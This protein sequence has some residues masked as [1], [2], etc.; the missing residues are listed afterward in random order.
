M[1]GVMSPLDWAVVEKSLALMTDQFLVEVRFQIMHLQSC[2][3]AEI[4]PILDCKPF[5]RG[6]TLCNRLFLLNRS[7]G[8]H[9]VYKIEGLHQLQHEAHEQIY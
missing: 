2:I 9:G 3:L 8:H 4:L 6:A 7:P 5:R 1:V